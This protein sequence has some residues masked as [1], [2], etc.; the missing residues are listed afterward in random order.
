MS[1]LR[2]P[3][4]EMLTCIATAIEARAAQNDGYGR[5]PLTRFHARVKPTISLKAYLDRCV[6]PLVSQGTVSLTPGTG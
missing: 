5:G 1:M 6:R 2:M 3:S 4:D